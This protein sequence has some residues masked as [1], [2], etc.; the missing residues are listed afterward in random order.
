M[1][2]S[3]SVGSGGS[4]PED[5]ECTILDVKNLELQP[6]VEDGPSLVRCPVMDVVIAPVECGFHC[7]I[8]GGEWFGW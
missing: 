2:W 8:R 6:V 7:D 4:F 5:Q 3:R 1:P